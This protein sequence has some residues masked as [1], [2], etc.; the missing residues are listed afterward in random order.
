[1]IVAIRFKPSCGLPQLCDYR[2][3]YTAAATEVGTAAA[4]SNQSDG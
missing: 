4:S 1:M 3:L 2:G